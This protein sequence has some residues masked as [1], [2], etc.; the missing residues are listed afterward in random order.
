ML[1]LRDLSSGGHRKFFCYGDDTCYISRANEEV[2]ISS[3]YETP[4][5]FIPDLALAFYIWQ[6]DIPLDLAIVVNPED[7]GGLSG[8]DHKIVIKESIKTLGKVKY[9]LDKTIE[10]LR[11]YISKI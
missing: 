6:G 11:E 5:D 9:D 1:K 4:I 10:K 2:Y 8:E 7:K 3:V